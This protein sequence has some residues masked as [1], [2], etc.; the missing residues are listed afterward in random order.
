MK[1]VANQTFIALAVLIFGH[2]QIRNMYIVHKN[3]IRIKKKWYTYIFCRH[4][5]KSFKL[6]IQLL[7]ISLHDL[8]YLIWGPKFYLNVGF[9]DIFKSINFEFWKSGT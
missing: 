8:K 9:T 5:Q 6:L 1:K 4:C 2:L 3:S 7:W